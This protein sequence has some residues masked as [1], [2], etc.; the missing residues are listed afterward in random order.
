MAH[1]NV[2]FWI[3]VKVK[4]R[5]IMHPRGHFQCH[6]VFKLAL[7]SD[8]SSTKCVKL[9][10]KVMK[11]RVIYI[12][13]V[14]LSALALGHLDKWLRGKMQLKNSCLCHI[15]VANKQLIKIIQ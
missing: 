11:G 15:F 4:I 10:G 8:L 14:C 2:L 13:G 1:L 6:N 7:S 5:F 3:C 9:F 12:V